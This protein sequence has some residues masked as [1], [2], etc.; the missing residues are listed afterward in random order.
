MEEHIEYSGFSF[1]RQGSMLEL[2]D[3]ER[4]A[5]P[6]LIGGD[7]FDLNALDILVRDLVDEEPG[8]SG[9]RIPFPGGGCSDY[10]PM[11]AG[12][13]LAVNR[14]ILAAPEID[15]VSYWTSDWAV[16]RVRTAGIFQEHIS[17]DSVMAEEG[18]ASLL[19]FGS[20]CRYGFNVGSGTPI[21][22][23]SL[24]FHPDIVSRHVQGDTDLL[25]ERLRGE[26]TDVCDLPHLIAWPGDRVMASLALEILQLD[27]TTPVFRILARS[28]TLRLFA[29]C[30]TRLTEDSTKKADRSVRL[31]AE[32][33][34]QL[35]VV[36]AVLDADLHHSH[37]LGELSRRAGINRRKLTEGFRSLFG[38]SV[39]EYAIKQRM[40][41]AKRLLLEGLPVG[42]VAEQVGYLDQGSFSR[43]FKRV[44]GVNPRNF[45]Q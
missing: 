39:G 20:G 7:Y 13:F 17:N 23:V 4:R 18:N 42:N 25:L 9:V 38:T 5:M 6:F 21:S 30:I 29:R 19:Y 8:L 34:K 32:D 22:S 1:H 41:R 33:I 24:I 31:R 26:V 36:R 35:E 16:L 43:A 28:L 12:C 2:I 44:V 40:R 37:T 3:P 45:T 15:S 14:N 10:F 11:E 27:I